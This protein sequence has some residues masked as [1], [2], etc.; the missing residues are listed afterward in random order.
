MMCAL[1][2]ALWMISLGTSYSYR[3]LTV[4]TFI[5]ESNL[6]S[7]KKSE[8]QGLRAVLV[9]LELSGIKPLRES[10]IATECIFSS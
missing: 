10:Y 6:L 2:V 7:T 5:E 3:Y 8:R 4:H 9:A 1:H